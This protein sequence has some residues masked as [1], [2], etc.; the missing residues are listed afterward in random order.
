MNY[1]EDKALSEWEYLKNKLQFNDQIS[2][3]PMGRY[4]ISKYTIKYCVYI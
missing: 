2:L 3:A 1:S 4:I